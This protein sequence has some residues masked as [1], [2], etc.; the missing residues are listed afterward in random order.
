MN[1]IF[2]KWEELVFKAQ[3]GDKASY[4]LFLTECRPLIKKIILKKVGPNF[5][6]DDIVQEVLWGIHKSLATYNRTKPLKPWV[7]AIVKFKICDFYRK[8]SK[9][10]KTEALENVTNT[11]VAT[12]IHTE[13]NI[14]G[15]QTALEAMPEALKTSVLLTQIKGLSY[16]EASEAEGISEVALRKRVSRAY[17]LMEKLMIEG[18]D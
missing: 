2:S 9:E 15:F 14:S 17:Q 5:D 11:P 7:L 16:R 3:D 10:I 18:V 8:K 12:N 13:G 1:E 6:V 4:R